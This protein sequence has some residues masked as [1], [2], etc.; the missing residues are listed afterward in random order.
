MLNHRQ[1]HACSSGSLAASP[2][3]QQNFIELADGEA[4]SPQGVAQPHHELLHLQEQVIV[5]AGVLQEGHGT[6][7]EESKQQ[8]RGRKLAPMEAHRRDQEAGGE[9]CNT[10][11]IVP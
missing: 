5:T 8:G 10:H 11:T 2:D 6:R 7:S 9:H 4:I 3:L 1:A